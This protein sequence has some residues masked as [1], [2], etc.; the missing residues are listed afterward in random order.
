MEISQPNSKLRSVLVKMCRR[1]LRIRMT[2]LSDK[3][4]TDYWKLWISPEALN[5]N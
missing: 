2:A 1:Q 3:I 4:A 5:L